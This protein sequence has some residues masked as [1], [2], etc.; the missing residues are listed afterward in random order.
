MHQ[1]SK[2]M[3]ESE[4]STCLKCGLDS[5]SGNLQEPIWTNTRLNKVPTFEKL[6][7][8]AGLT[9]EL[10]KV[11]VTR[12]DNKELFGLSPNQKSRLNWLHYVVNKNMKAEL[13]NLAGELRAERVALESSLQEL[14]SFKDFITHEI[15][16]QISQSLDLEI[17]IFNQY[18]KYRRW[19]TEEEVN[20]VWERQFREF[21]SNG[22]TR[23]VIDFKESL[24][25]F[26]ALDW[27]EPSGYAVGS[28]SIPK[29]AFHYQRGRGK[30]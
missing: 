28:T 7:R 26:S 21:Q 12:L 30:R 15:A 17:G 4:D 9:R 19:A 29:E 10:L 13:T 14:G 25:R 8:R 6:L 24:K 27:V 16:P 22:V 2:C 5:T 18:L 11:I 3:F 20:Q 23:Y 1:C